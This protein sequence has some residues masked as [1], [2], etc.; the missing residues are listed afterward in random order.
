MAVNLVSDCAA[1]SR[2]SPRTRRNAYRN[3]GHWTANGDWRRRERCK[4][5]GRTWVCSD[6]KLAIGRKPGGE[7]SK[8]YVQF[9]TTFLREC[10]RVG[11][12]RAGSLAAARA[13]ITNRSTYTRW[14]HTP[15]AD[16]IA[17]LVSNM[18]RER[19]ALIEAALSVWSGDRTPPRMPR[20]DRL[21]LARPWQELVERPTEDLNVY[22]YFRT[23]S[24]AI[25]QLI[26]RGSA[27]T[28]VVTGRPLADWV[29]RIQNP[30]HELWAS[31]LAGG[32]LMRRGNR[33]HTSDYSLRYWLLFDYANY[34]SVAVVIATRSRVVCVV[35]MGGGE[36]PLK[37][38]AIQLRTNEARLGG[39]G[40]VRIP[41]MGIRNPYLPQ[42]HYEL[43]LPLRSS[44]SFDDRFW[45]DEQYP[46]LLATRS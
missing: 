18:A 28:S 45:N 27:I 1:C 25:W 19:V 15:R 35:S 41:L 21:E 7:G 39:Q 43:E 26:V 24:P 13:G 8:T 16:V 11:I 36:P 22:D 37:E 4:A 40:N 38:T 17:P 5:C 33:R 12:P 9:W 14:L 44:Y 3:G 32:N 23:C 10:T 34:G 20:Y 31:V 2:K 6:A 29:L 46:R 30:P 42:E